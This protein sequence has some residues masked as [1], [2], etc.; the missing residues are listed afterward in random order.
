[1]PLP[2]SDK[3]RLSNSKK[4]LAASQ[5]GSEGTTELVFT[6]KKVLV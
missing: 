4:I 3:L 1:M 6:D 5:Q 2:T